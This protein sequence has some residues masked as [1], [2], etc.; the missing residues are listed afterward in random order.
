MTATSTS[1]HRS[2]LRQLLAW[3]LV[4]A[5]C[6]AL[7]NAIVDPLRL[8]DHAG[9]PGWTTNKPALR[10]QERLFKPFAV[11]RQQPE[12]V[13][14]GS[15]RSNHALDPDHRV[16]AGR[17]AYNLSL[18]GTNVA[19]MRQ[20]FEHA[21]AQ[22]ALQRAVV[23]LDI[24]FFSATAQGSGGGFDYADT[25]AARH[26]WQRR[27]RTLQ[28]AWA[29]DT[30]AL[31]WQ[32]LRGQDAPWE[33]TVNG[34]QGDPVFEHRIATYGGVRNT[35][36]GYMTR[37]LP[38]E[39]QLASSWNAAHLPADQLPGMQDLRAM[40]DLARNHGVQVTL[41]LSPVHAIDALATRAIF[42]V[43]RI[44]AWRAAI[45]RLA[46]AQS[47][48]SGGRFEVPVWDFSGF[49]SVTTEAVPDR[50]DRHSRM[51]HYWDQSHYRQ[52]VGDWILDRIFG[53]PSAGDAVP[54]DF[55]VRLEAQKLASHFAI[56]RAA[57][58]NYAISHND[59][60]RFV[61]DLI[62]GSTHKSSDQ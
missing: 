44:E 16:F 25:V 62:H 29:W 28:T 8:L 56:E 11:V 4:P 43:E 18:S 38:A 39:Q 35:V 42:G 45:V 33:Y 15:S 3:S 57:A 20:M 23:E 47:Q 52:Q 7:F 54:A 36:E 6:V 40:L 12:V 21:L 55:G 30:V 27:L 60:A 31:S 41:Y 51:R 10:D 1:P 19:E 22:G 59:V 53:V 32:T 46:D 61:S 17:R 24:G 2:Y 34:R 49:N 37:L 13:L 5:L 58:E 9:V 14:L 48:L 26:P 50:S